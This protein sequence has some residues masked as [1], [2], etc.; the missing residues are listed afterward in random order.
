MFHVKHVYCRCCFRDCPNGSPAGIM[1]ESTHNLPLGTTGDSLCVCP[2][3]KDLH[4]LII[5]I[6]WS[7]PSVSSNF[8]EQPTP[9][10]C[11]RSTPLS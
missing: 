8:Q 1:A 4:F 6:H 7:Y 9:E 10:I 2:C 11:L 3:I 5:A